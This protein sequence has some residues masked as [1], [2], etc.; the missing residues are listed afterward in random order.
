MQSTVMQSVISLLIATSGVCIGAFVSITEPN[1]PPIHLIAN[2]I[3][4]YSHS[5]CHYDK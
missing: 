1:A 3:T 4:I 2:A 5:R